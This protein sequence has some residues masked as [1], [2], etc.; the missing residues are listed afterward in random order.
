MRIINDILDF[1]KIEAGKL[2]LE[3]QPF[4]LRQCAESAL[5]LLAPFAA[6]KNLA[7]V[8]LMEAAIPPSIVGDVTRVRQIL[9][10]LL[11]NAVKFTPQGEVVIEVTRYS[12]EA[13]PHELQFAV[14]DTGIG[15]SEESRH[16]LFQSFSQVDASTTRKYGGTGL[17]LAI[18][19]RLAELMGGR[20]WVE[21][22]G[23]SGKGTTFFFT[24]RAKS[25]N[26]PLPVYLADNVV[27]RGKRV[28]IMDDNATNR[29]LLTQQ[30]Q[31]WGMVPVVATSAL[32]V[33]EW[34]KRGDRF[35]LAVLDRELPEMDGE[36]LAAAIQSYRDASMLP[37]IM[38]TSLGGRVSS[39]P[40]TFSAMVTKPIKVS[41]LY[42]AV[43]GVLA[44]QS[45]R[46]KSH[47]N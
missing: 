10:N 17:G 5:E 40:S 12:D 13:E 27:L 4:D 15:I 42:N 14:R 39:M 47:H 8:L 6:Q 19:K 18:S 41:P 28:L 43:I 21:S 7:L 37:L 24:I 35:D 32:A 36:T 45:A 30:S 1:S 23:L 22:D 31:A 16:R 11:S 3:E 44:Q 9:V 25:A 26:F 29:R 46:S 2:E 34:I 20:I 33:L 38:L